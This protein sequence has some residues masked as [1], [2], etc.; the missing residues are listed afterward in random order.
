MNAQQH[1]PV[2]LQEALDGLQVQP[3]G[4][5]VDATFG[6]GGHARELLRRLLD[7]NIFLQPLQGNLQ[8]K[9]PPS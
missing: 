1:Y 5:Y 8:R 2:L 7:L 6:R 9:G 3:G 4:I